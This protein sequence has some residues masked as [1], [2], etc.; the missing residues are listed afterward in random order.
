M[1]VFGKTKE[2]TV[3]KITGA[4]KESEKVKERDLKQEEF[5]KKLEN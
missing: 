4:F 2:L 3:D 5:N 1:A